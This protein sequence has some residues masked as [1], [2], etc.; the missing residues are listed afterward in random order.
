[1]LDALEHQSC[2]FERMIE[3]LQP[4]RARHH[5]P[6]FQVM[7][8]MQNAPAPTLA[9]QGLAVIPIH[10]NQGVAKLDLTFSLSPGSTGY[11]GWLEY[12]TDIFV[13]ETAARMARHF[14][15]LLEQVT[16]EPSKPIDELSLMPPEECGA[17][18]DWGVAP[19]SPSDSSCFH[20][21]VEAWAEATP[22]APALVTEDDTW[23]YRHLNAQANR[24]ARR[25]TS[26][27]VGPESI[28]AVVMPR[29]PDAIVAI[30]AVHKAG[31]A[32]AP[33]DPSYPRA[34]V[35]FMLQDCG[36]A[37]VLT[38]DKVKEMVSVSR[39]ACLVVDECMDHSAGECEDNLGEIACPNNLAY[40]IYTSGSTGRPKGT[41]LEHAGIMNMWRFQRDYLDVTSRDQVLQFASLS[42]D[43]SVWEIV[44]A[45]GNGATLHL[46]SQTHLATP[47]GI[48]AIFRTRQITI[49]TLPP[50]LLQL[51]QQCSYPALRVLIAAG[52]TC[53]PEVASRWASGRRFFNAYGPTEVTVGATIFECR[54]DENYS[55]GVPIGR[56]MRNK[57]LYVVDSQLRLVP[58]GVPGELLVGGVGLARGYLNRPELSDERFIA[59]SFNGHQPVRVYRT[60]DMVKWRHDG[61]LVHLGRLDDQVK[62]RGFRVELG[63]IESMLG[64]QPEIRQATVL[65]YT[66]SLGDCRLAAYLVPANG[67]VPT[68]Q[69]IKRRLAAALPDFM[70]PAE[71]HV[72]EALPVT[73]TGKVD[74]RALRAHAGSLLPSAQASVQPRDTTELELHRLWQNLF[75]GQRLGV[76]D[77]FFMLGGHSLLAV[78]LAAQVR[79]SFGIAFPVSGIFENPTIERLAAAVKR[80]AS[81]APR[82]LVPIQPNGTKRPFFCVHSAPGSVFCYVAL[83]RHL[84]SDQPF[85]GLQAAGLED[86]GAPLSSIGDMAARYLHEVRKVQPH[87]PYRLGGHSLG[88]VVSFEMARRLEEEG[89]CVSVLAILDC[90]PPPCGHRSADVYN[91]VV[92]ATPDSLWLAGFARLI[93]QFFGRRL[94][95]S[96]KQLAR[97]SPEQQ[98]EL[99]LTHLKEVEFLPPDA[100]PDF[101]EA[102]VSVCKA[103]FRAAYAFVPGPFHGRIT[104]FKS[105]AE[106]LALPNGAAVPIAKALWQVARQNPIRFTR[107]LPQ[108]LRDAW[109]TS[110]TLRA[111]RTRPRLGWEHFS[112]IPLQCHVVTGNHVTMLTEPHVRD[113]AEKLSLLLDSDGT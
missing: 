91:A 67:V 77:D 37:L 113:V 42:F 3:A 46:A 41:L 7:L 26:L 18:L 27:G 96:V 35:A 85:Y 32:Y 16:S 75:P 95:L 112:D 40:V 94:E 102:M 109:T 2:P 97:L 108:L 11:T 103:G 39:A 21:V 71:F 49:A 90:A 66:D 63:E 101:V 56:A 79:E 98:V 100:K 20:H 43:G 72:V 45:L 64:R 68:S 76:K 44:M 51:M 107:A 14:V 104:F 61:Q 8:A 5:A 93:E 23:T 9:L 48:D 110:R 84:G 58:P 111:S 83:A 73:P 4:H 78:H 89:E 1:M 28:V 99:I 50:A 24:L 87:G 12:N 74:R 17:I 62:I 29:S 13:D 59:M 105:E 47:Q 30:L 6:I 81:P 22:D 34:R 36:A 55:A 82:C 15:H 54:P 25:L 53:P 69:E 86:A 33:I 52:E 31:G 92:A 60:G 106:F 10:V 57:A 88:G 19:K 80:D 38:H 65:P 70:L